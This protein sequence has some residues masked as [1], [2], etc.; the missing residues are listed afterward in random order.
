VLYLGL[1]RGGQRVTGGL[2]GRG[3]RVGAPELGVA[4]ASGA[5]AVLTTRVGSP[6]F[7]GVADMTISL[8]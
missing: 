2:G 3:R 6:V 7:G 5:A 4:V 1:R 8:D